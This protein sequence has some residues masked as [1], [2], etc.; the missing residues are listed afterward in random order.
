MRGGFDAIVVGS[1]FGGAVTACR[2]AERGRRVLVLERGRRWRPADYPRAPGDAWIWDHKRPE[3]DNGWMELRWFRRMG[4]AQGAGVGGGSLIFANVVVDATPGTFERGWPS[5]ITAAGMARYYE[6]VARMLCV[7]PLPSNQTTAR[8]RLLEEAAAN[9]GFS[10]RF[11]SLPLAVTFDPEWHYGL[12]DPFS[13]RHTKIWTNEHGQLQGTC[14]HCGN[15]D[16]GCQVRAK[17]TLDLNYL[18]RAEQ[19]GAEIRPLHVV[20]SLAPEAGGYRVHF[21]R[22]EDGTQIAGSEVAPVVVL[23][24]GSLGSTELLLRCRDEHR[25]LPGVSQHLGLGWSSNADFL[26]PA[27]YRDR[28]I[29]PTRGPTITCA[30]DFLDGA[31]GEQF[32]IEDGGFPDM[33]H[34]I[35]EPMNARGRRTTLLVAAHHAADRA[36]AIHRTV[37]QTM[38]F[39]RAG[40]QWN[41]PWRSAL[42]SFARLAGQD[43]PLRGTMP[44]FAQGIDAGDGVL[45][46]AGRRR[47]RRELAMRWNIRRSRAVIDAIV[48]MHV[49]LSRATG[50]RARVPIS[51]SLMKQLV[52][53]HPLGGCN[54]G[55]TPADGVVNH[56]GE[57]FGY[58]GLF[59]ADGAIVPRAIGLNPSKTIAALAERIADLMFEPR[60]RAR[61]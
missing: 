51:W 26:T 61:S 40:Q 52:T 15:C 31:E 2:L 4:V 19:C 27:T 33:L 25:S 22:L 36:S 13:G 42:Q 5:E 8:Y 41:H 34:N 12:D 56:R 9:S 49:R 44:W 46:L 50:G 60:D 47:G 57:V 43:D 24:A 28:A 23:A 18:A 1:G 16:I 37:R 45:Y 55:T 17:N 6:P 48:A 11:R 32:F 20:T 38:A 7:Q 21:A 39:A 53:P 29:S 30:L 14:V 54:M 35:A 3:R 10:N 58:P 59:V